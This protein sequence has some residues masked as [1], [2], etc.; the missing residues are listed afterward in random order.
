MATILVI[1][2]TRELRE[3]IADTLGR[4]GFTVLTAENGL[5]GLQMIHNYQLNLVVCDVVMPELGGLDLLQIVRKDES[6][7]M[8]PFI[9]LTA[10]SERQDMRLAMQMGADDY[11]T[12]PFTT[13]ELVNA[14]KARIQKFDL[15]KK[16]FDVQ[17][18]K[19]GQKL[20]YSSRHDELTGLPNQVLFRELLKEAVS[21]A[22][23]YRIKFGLLLLDIDKFN[24]IN[25][26]LGTKIG[27][28]LFKAIAERLRRHANACD[29][30]ARLRGDEFAV[31]LNS[32]NTRDGVQAEAVKILRILST[33]FNLC[34]H[35]IF[36][37]ASIGISMFGEDTNSSE[38]LFKNVDLAM[39]YAKKHSR[40]TYRW[41]S[42]ELNTQSAEHLALVNNLHRALTKDEIKI[43]YQPQ[44]DIKTRKIVGAEALIRWQHPY[45]GIVTP[46]KFIPV[47]EETGVIINIGEYVLNRVCRQI[48]FWNDHG[49][50]M[51]RISVNLS[52][53]HFF[54]G[55]AIVGLLAEALE[56]AGIPRDS[57][58]LEITESVIMQTAKNTTRIL[59]KLRAMG[60][61]IAIDDFG[62][63]YSS[64]SYL[65]HFPVDTLK[66]DR[67]FVQDLVHDRH[68]AAITTAIIEMSH[69]LSLK[70]V[71][72]GVETK[73]Q[74]A[75]LEQNGC[76]LVQG[77]LF[78]RP[79]PPDEFAVLFQGQPYVHFE[80]SA[81]F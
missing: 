21:H 79:L 49:L 20:E 11:L 43:F 30:V 66:V 62:T 45:L 5:I 48:R 31:I 14:I 63:G 77:F 10:K 59:L 9:F 53:Q 52:G 68:D 61:Q 70:V 76:D 25:N 67:C 71:A 28:K 23:S 69:H 36:L 73:E 56:N 3:E 60:I 16:H 74:F 7:C 46:D 13:Q 57:L 18:E 72:E 38:E 55:D 54:E 42:P 41:Y 75:F 37:S 78:S 35:D 34:G 17:T 8:L 81:T 2:D 26:T 65:K 50:K 6:T 27:D 33:A 24:I 22:Q 47:A 29:V 12:K 58:E 19:L 40:N 51:G 64:L 4:Q 39:Y 1:E 15:V 44:I 80:P 32:L